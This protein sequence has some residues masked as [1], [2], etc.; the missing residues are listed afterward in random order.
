MNL[1]FDAL[2]QISFEHV[3]WRD[4]LADDAMRGRAK[5]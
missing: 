4:E 5:R 1:R 2:R 3:R